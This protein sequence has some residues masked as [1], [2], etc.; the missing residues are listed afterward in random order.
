MVPAAVGANINPLY[1]DGISILSHQKQTRSKLTEIAM[2]NYMILHYGFEQ[3]T[4]EEMKAWK[5]WFESISDI[6]IDKGGLR[7]G[8][9]IT[10]S[11]TK[12]LPFGK[13]S[14]TGYTII[15]AENLDEAVKIAK[16]CPIV[17]STK[18]YETS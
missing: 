14:I 9:E 1:R 12:E 13:N 2:K 15:Q 17:D 5:Q 3:P 4:S 16:G 10:P 7:G 18:V 8:R 6:Q 11:E